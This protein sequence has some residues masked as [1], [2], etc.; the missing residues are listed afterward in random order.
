MESCK[1]QFLFST[2]SD[3]TKHFS[4]QCE[5]CEVVKLVHRNW[6]DSHCNWS[7]ARQLYYCS[8]A[9]LANTLLPFLPKAH[10]HT[11]TRTHT[12]RHTHIL[13]LCAFFFLPWMSHRSGCQFD[14]V[15]LCLWDR[16]EW[17]FHSLSCLVHCHAIGWSAVRNTGVPN[18][19]EVCVLHEVC[20]GLT[21][22]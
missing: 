10:T 22:P 21:D 18:V 13:S 9:L 11:H 19:G 16:H 5:I 3:N 20:Q 14:Y 2:T 6:S 4:K 15:R 1:Q 7:D 8:L 17:R 12:C